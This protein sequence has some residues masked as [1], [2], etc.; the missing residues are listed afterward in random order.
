MLVL[1]MVVLVKGDGGIGAGGVGVD[2]GNV[3]GV[4]SDYSDVLVLV[5]LVV[6]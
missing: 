4:G 2:W 1:L 5:V 6:E 3:N